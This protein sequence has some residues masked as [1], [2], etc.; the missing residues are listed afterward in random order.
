MASLG[1]AALALAFLASIVSVAALL[2]G[3][4]MGEEQG[5]TFTNWGYLATF[6]ALAGYT[7]GVVI[8][9]YAM[10]TNGFSLQYVAENHSTDV[11]NLAWLYK[12]SGLWA[13]REGSLLFWS[14]LL[15][16][17]AS[18]IAW[19]RISITDAL[20][21]MGLMITNV[22]LALFGAAMLF[23]QPNNPFKA[24]PADWLG[25]NG[26]LLVQTGMNPLLQHWAMILHPPTLFIGYAGLTIPFA[27][28]V[29]A[30]IVNDG[31]K[32]WVEITNRITVFAWLFLGMGIGLGAI[33]AYVVLGWGGY[34]AWDPVENA[35]LLPWLTGVGLLHSFTVYRRRDGFKKW[36]IVN[37][38]VTFALVIL[39]TFITRSGIVQSVHAFQE[40][41]VSLFLFLGMIIGALV[42]GIGGVLWR[43]A[44]FEGH[45]EF[46]S[47]T[48][49]DAAYYFNNV[50]ML[51]AS[52]IVAYLTVSSAL[53][54]WMPG[55][56][57]NFGAQT[58]DAIARPVGILYAFILAVCP[59]LSWRKTDLVTFQKRVWKPAA[60]AAVLFALLMLEWF[61]TL[62]PIF[63][64]I[65]QTIA[66]GAK[67]GVSVI[68]PDWWHH[69]QAI[70]AFAAASL[71]ISTAVWLFID[72]AT[73][74]ARG[75]GENFFSALWAILSKARSQ[76]GGYIAHI[77]I[78]VILIGLV[79]SAMYVDDIRV[80][81]PDKPGSK[82]AVD[83]YEFTYRSIEQN[84]L[85]NQDVISTATFDMTRDGKPAGTLTP[86]QTQFAVQG[87]SRLNVDVLSEPLRDVFI[88]FE[89]TQ[90]NNIS[91]NVKIN[92]L[93]WFSWIGFILLLLGSSL[94]AWPKAGQEEPVP[95]REKAS[96]KK[97]PRPA[98]ATR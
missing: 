36:A 92:P 81:I 18:W 88:V 25:P 28:A 1:I 94:A 85:P 34:W 40:D 17:F 24:S 50:L 5:E 60:T 29:A 75:R 33:W 16:A 82:F 57:Q 42:I 59:L 52:I 20:S 37:A 44:T 45:E 30:I 77:G 46:E 83:R 95:V 78:G 98:A 73:G 93:I 49:K 76:S 31:S 96:T 6:A 10:F 65:K 35:S 2:L 12:L 64:K 72:G 48:S 56:G 87:Q 62:Q 39:G 32:L 3:R 51:V 61:Q 58:Y 69:A 90:G 89:G 68:G 8:I 54:A 71:I 43:G 13:G 53:P 19:R 70:A 67:P 15:A 14:W 63:G 41:P 66:S 79:G 38:S 86:G 80:Q 55:G 74:R 27:F 21:N 4:S 47:L 22:I 26:E 11:S 7:V 84:Q 23:S 97:K 91:I 9:V